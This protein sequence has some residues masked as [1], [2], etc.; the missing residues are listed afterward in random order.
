PMSYQLVEIADRQRWNEALLS[1]PEPHL[2]Q[3]WQW[4][5]AKAE[6]GWQPSRWLWLDE[7][8]TAKAAAQV[9]ERRAGPST[10]GLNV[11]YCPK[12]PILDW[13]DEDMRRQ[14]LADLREFAHSQRAIQIKVDPDVPLGRGVPGKESEERTGIGVELTADLEDLDWRPSP[15]QI[16]FRNTMILDLAREEDDILADMKSKTRYNVR[17]A[18]RRGVEV[19]RGGLGDLDLMYRMFAETALRDGFTI[20][21]REYYHTVWGR[22]IQEDLAQPLIAE[23]EG[24]P[25][26][27]LIVYRFGQ[28]SWYLYGMSIDK[29]RDKM[30]N[31]L[32]QW[33]AIRWSKDHGCTSYDLWGA[34]DKFD[35]SDPMWGVYRFK[36]GFKAEVLRTIGAWDYAP[37][38]FL[39]QLY[40][41]ALPPLLSVMRRLGRRQTA[42][43]LD[44]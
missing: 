32:L 15:E 29:H 33:E 41:R 44:D 35:K 38:P 20:R 18:G 7:E 28:R 13:Q 34:P 1:L 23:V 26:A 4:G 42:S 2:L 27:G 36:R 30:P 22:F 43:A 17:L 6:T 24:E 21:N 40:H 11:L 3:S 9:L 37:R 25:V 16:Q 39:Y 10:F 31:Y 12:G 14:V 8:G 19:R 5:E